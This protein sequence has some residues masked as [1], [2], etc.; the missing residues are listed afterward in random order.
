MADFVIIPTKL[1]VE[2]DGA[3]EAEVMVHCQ[4]SVVRCPRCSESAWRIAVSI[5][6]INSGG[7]LFRAR[8]YRRADLSAFSI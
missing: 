3:A 4:S 5:S 6:A 7:Q 2:E 8:R 1:A